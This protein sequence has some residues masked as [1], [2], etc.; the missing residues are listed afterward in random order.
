MDIKE[1]K[2]EEEKLNHILIKYDEVM[3]YYKNRINLIFT[4]YANNQTMIEN[5]TEIY[6][7]KIRLMEK[8]LNKP[9]FARLDFKRDGESDIEELYIGKVGVIDEKNDNI[10]IDWRAPV[11]S[12]Y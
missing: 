1:F 10:I 7:E 2:K 12:M 6:L 11:S 4:T 3:K 8:S 5:L 9:Y